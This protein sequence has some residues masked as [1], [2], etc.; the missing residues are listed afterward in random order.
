MVQVEVADEAV[1][2]RCGDMQEGGGDGVEKWAVGWKGVLV[3]M[4]LCMVLV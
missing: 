4:W 2:E 3:C 1:E